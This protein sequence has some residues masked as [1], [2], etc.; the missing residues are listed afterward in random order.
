MLQKLTKRL[1]IN[2]QLA[3]EPNLC[4]RFG[5]DDLQTIGQWCWAGYQR[6]KLS[7]SKWEI[8]SQAAMDLA[9]QIQLDK[10]FPWPG[11]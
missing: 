3:K 11:C 2:R 1:E 7:R 4:D 8:R 5:A 6:D 10:S 9:M